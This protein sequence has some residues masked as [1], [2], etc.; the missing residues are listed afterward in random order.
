MTSQESFIV[1][2]YSAEGER[3]RNEQVI[4][5]NLDSEHLDYFAKKF[6]HLSGDLELPLED[7]L[8]GGVDFLDYRIGSDLNGAY[9][10]YYFHDEVIFASLLLS[11]TD[12]PI[13]TELM[14]VFKFLLLDTNDEDEPS[15]E[16]IEEVLSSEAF[17]FPE[18]ENRPAVFEVQLAHEDALPMD[19]VIS[20]NRHL[21]AAF[22]AI[23]R[24]LP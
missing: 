7:Q 16:E 22:F 14:Q 19:H 18:V 23:D 21:G 10:L 4:A 20:L 1:T 6:C 2:T 5:A 8:P 9:V 15:E 24:S 12:E 17:D 11:G 13:E 3:L